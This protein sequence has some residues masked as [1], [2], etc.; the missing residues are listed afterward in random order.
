MPI[1][2][3]E[4]SV[5]NYYGI[6][7]ARYFANVVT[8]KFSGSAL[9]NGMI[10]GNPWIWKSDD[11]NLK[12]DFTVK[13]DFPS[14]MDWESSLTAVSHNMCFRH[15]GVSNELSENGINSNQQ[16]CIND[17]I[18]QL[19]IDY[20]NTPHNVLISLSLKKIIKNLY[21]ELKQH[22]PLHKRTEMC[23][24]NAISFR[25]ILNQLSQTNMEFHHITMMLLYAL[26]IDSSDIE[27][28]IADVNDVIRHIRE[29]NE[30]MKDRIKYIKI[31]KPSFDLSQESY[32]SSQNSVDNYG[33]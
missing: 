28:Q 1:Y 26:P 33:F 25:F 32:I 18:T 23:A 17:N 20:P 2:S 13:S 15:R 29:N 21:N 5:H 19:K 27:L 7:D 12:D 14:I 8:E 30:L 3:F 31:G 9:N 6:R 10:E 11:W 4:G 22:D 16:N 24:N